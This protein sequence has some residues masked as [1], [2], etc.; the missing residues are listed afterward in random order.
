MQK[1]ICLLIRFIEQ[2]RRGYRCEG[3]WAIRMSETVDYRHVKIR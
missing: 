3:K 2:K 1:K